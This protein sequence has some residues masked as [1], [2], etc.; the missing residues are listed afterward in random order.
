[1][2]KKAGIKNL[3][4][5]RWRHTYAHE[6][7]AAGGDT[8]DL[9]LV[10]GWSSETMARHYGASAAAQR[11]QVAQDRLAIGDDLRVTR[12]GCGDQLIPTP[13]LH[14]QFRSYLCFGSCSPSLSR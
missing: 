4:A 8:G 7:K 1:M 10:L 12:V 11:A 6:W 9:M 14:W 13:H 5:H 2:G 3:H